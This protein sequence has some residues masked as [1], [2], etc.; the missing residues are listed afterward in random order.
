MSNLITR[1]RWSPYL[2]G[3]GIGVLSWVAFAWMG[4][5]LGTSTT[6]VNVAG[7][8][9]GVVSGQHVRETEYLAKHIVG[10]PVFDW[11][12]ALVIALFIGAVGVEMILRAIETTFLST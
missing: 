8:I 10:K 11:Q 2:V 4:K 6:M 3:A 7:A 9:E 12:F 1:P 5:A